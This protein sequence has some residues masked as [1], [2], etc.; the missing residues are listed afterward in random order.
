MSETQGNGPWADVETAVYRQFHPGRAEW[1]V[2]MLRECRAAVEAAHRAEIATRLEEVEHWVKRYNELEQWRVQQSVML[3]R[4]EAQIATL[5]EAATPIA[6]MADAY[7]PPENDDRILMWSPK[8]TL[9]Q[10]RALR[11]ALEGGTQETPLHADEVEWVVNDSAELGVKIGQRFFWCYKGRSLVYRDGTHDD[12]TPMYWRPVFKR[13]F[14]ECIHPINYRDLTKIGTVSLDDSDEWKP[15][16]ALA[17]T[18][19]PK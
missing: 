12:G 10:V 1:V 4:R 7:D 15:L 3:A 13:E 6:R 5:R 8:P 16:P 19:P 18:E 11:A 17:A 9:G 2:G 14:G